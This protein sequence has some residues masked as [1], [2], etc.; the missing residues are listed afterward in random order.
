MEK[1][2]TFLPSC[3]VIYQY[4]TTQQFNNITKEL[5]INKNNFIIIII[6][7]HINIRS[8]TKNLNKLREFI[9]TLII[10]PHNDFKNNITNYTYQ[11]NYR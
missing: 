10:K 1:L 6:Y 7:L 2:D 3:V 5:I 9:D 8:L 4:K 11:T